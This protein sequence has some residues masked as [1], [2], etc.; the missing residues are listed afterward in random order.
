MR[1]AARVGRTRIGR[2]EVGEPAAEHPGCAALHRHGSEGLHGA[3][4]DPG[5]RGKRAGVWK[6][7]ESGR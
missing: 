4:W 6:L 7:V 3:P 5:S 1:G 2:E